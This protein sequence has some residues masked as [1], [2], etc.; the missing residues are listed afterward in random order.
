M[1]AAVAVDDKSK[2]EDKV[3]ALRERF[4]KRKQER[5]IQVEGSEEVQ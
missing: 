4:L 2:Q 3:K 1:K 5:T